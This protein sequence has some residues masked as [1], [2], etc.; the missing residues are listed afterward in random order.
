MYHRN[1]LSEIAGDQACHLLQSTLILEFSASEIDYISGDVDLLN[2]TYDVLLK[3]KVGVNYGSKDNNS[4]FKSS[5]CF[6]CLILVVLTCASHINIR[7]LAIEA[8]KLGMMDQGE[9]LFLNFA[10][11]NK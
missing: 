11:Y 4:T 3:E 2:I 7:K 10:L 9:Y 6:Y 5:L 1:Q 8:V